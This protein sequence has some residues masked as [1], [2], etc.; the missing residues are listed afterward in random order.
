MKEQK[1]RKIIRETIQEEQGR[2][3]LG[4]ANPLGEIHRL[5]Y[6][7]GGITQNRG[8]MVIEFEPANSESASAEIPDNYVKEAE[9]QAKKAVSKISEVEVAYQGGVTKFFAYVDSSEEL[10]KRDIKALNLTELVL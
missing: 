1:L 5:A 3:D 8:K 6:E 4:T 9:I 7:F 10:T 2:G